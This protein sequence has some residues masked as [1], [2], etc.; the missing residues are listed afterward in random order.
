[1]RITEPTLE[2]HR[3][4]TESPGI[5]DTAKATGPHRKG[6]KSRVHNATGSQPQNHRSSLSNRE[7]EFKAG[8]TGGNEEQQGER[9][10]LRKKPG[11]ARIQNQDSKPGFTVRP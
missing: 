2:S 8:E 11:K 4:I 5:A 1:M 9:G 3:G 10:Q 7:P 6:Y